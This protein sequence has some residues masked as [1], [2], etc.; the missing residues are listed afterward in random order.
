MQVLAPQGEPSFSFT[1]A[2]NDKAL[3]RQTSAGY[4]SLGDISIGVQVDDTHDDTDTKRRILMCAS[5]TTSN[6]NNHNHSHTNNDDN[7]NHNAFG[8]QL[9]STFMPPDCQ[10]HMQVHRWLE[11][12]ESQLKMRFS[13]RNTGK[14]ASSV[15]SVLQVARVGANRCCICFLCD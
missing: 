1:F 10:R 8:N 14:H 9:L 2:S 7:N 5:Q 13:I 15:C 4:H 6:N 12:H 11:V 3:P